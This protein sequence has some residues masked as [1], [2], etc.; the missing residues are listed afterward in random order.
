MATVVV[1][2][3]GGFIGSN[4]VDGLLAQG[5]EVLAIDDFSTGRESNLQPAAAKYGK[6]LCVEKAD[7]RT[8]DLNALF[9]SFKPQAVY[10]LAAQMSVPRS[11][12]E[13]VFDASINV[14]GMVNVLE[15][16]RLNNVPRFMFS[17][18][19]GAIYGE[20]NYFPADEEH[21]CNS[22]CQYG[23]AK[24]CGE[25]Y[26]AY[27]SRFY[28]FGAVAFRFANVYGPRQ[29]PKGEAGVVAMFMERL[30][31]GQDILVNGDGGQ[32][33]DFVFVGDIV[34]GVIMGT[35][36]LEPGKMDIFNLGTGKETDINE[37][38]K[39][40]ADAWVELN[41]DSDRSKINIV[42]LPALAGEQR[43]SVVAIDKMKARYGWQPEVSLSEGLKITFATGN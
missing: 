35:V 24:R 13:P 7:I 36:K 33:R 32:T 41:K 26:L 5:D 1:T 8:A 9:G 14:L 31:T 21:P 12:K 27:Y 23:V 40:A 16:A 4:L 43:R 42:H 19:G 6:T 30:R 17:S 29:N 10:H 15:A 22:E 20:Q 37:L 2:G 25:L 28:N 39:R 34:R 38:A 3:G 18:T 11:V